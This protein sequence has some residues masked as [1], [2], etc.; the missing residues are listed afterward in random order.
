[1]LSK[2]P[3]APDLGN[4]FFRVQ[5]SRNTLPQI[6]RKTLRTGETPRNDI[7][8]SLANNP[9]KVRAGLHAATVSSNDVTEE[10]RQL[11]GDSSTAPVQCQVGPIKYGGGARN[12]C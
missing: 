1:M 8:K 3:G 6:Q 5:P 10:P 11:P 9:T 4:I 12:I 2:S 7:Q